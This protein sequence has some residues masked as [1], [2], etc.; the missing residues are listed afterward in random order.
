MARS[1]RATSTAAG[2]ALRRAIAEDTRRFADA[3]PGPG[4]QTRLN[5]IESGAEL[6]LDSGE[7]HRAMS[8]I[9]THAARRFSDAADPGNRRTYRLTTDNQLLEISRDAD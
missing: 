4:W 3:F 1:T 5:R 8:R 7:L 6:I 2:A 9:S